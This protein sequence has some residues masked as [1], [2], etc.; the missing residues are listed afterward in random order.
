[1]EERRTDS[2]MDRSTSKLE[3]MLKELVSYKHAGDMPDMSPEVQ[4]LINFHI[5]LHKPIH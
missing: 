1:M 2:S 5:S 4:V 3:S